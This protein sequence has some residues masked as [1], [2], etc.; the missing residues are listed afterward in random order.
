MGTARIR[1]GTTLN[2]S[3][4]LTFF[5]IA[6]L[7]PM[8]WFL[9]HDYNY[10]ATVTL[11]IAAITD[12]LDGYFARLW[13]QVSDFGKLMDPIADKIFVSVALFL[14]VA[15]PIR[16]LN[17]WLASILVAREFFVSGLRTLF[18]SRG[19]ILGA[20]RSAKWK[21]AFQFFGIGAVILYEPLFS[22]MPMSITVGNLFLLASVILSFWSMAKYIKRFRYSD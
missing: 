12:G 7:L 4:C 6:L 8:G 3:N 2:F 22:F 16:Q 9:Q 20:E 18:A 5:R 14:L 1:V 11:A 17:P 13:N 21:T 10:C 19:V 15:D